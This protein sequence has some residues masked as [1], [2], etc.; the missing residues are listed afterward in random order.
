MSLSWIAV[1][2]QTQ[3]IAHRSTAPPGTLEVGIAAFGAVYVG[4]ALFMA[5]APHAFYTVIG[6]FETLNVHYI[7]D[8][9]TFNAAIG[10][11]LLVAVR[12]PSWQVPALAISTLQF[13]LH[14]I[15]HL[16]DIDRA[17]PAWV[18]YFDFFSLAVATLGLAWL[19]QVALAEEGTADTVHR[20]EGAPQ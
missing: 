9:A 5:A 7:R 16:V 17:H 13:A 10:V 18:G 4:L 11:G 8:A 2:A 19:L 14:S 15:N 6:P 20:P 1:T 3:P 12:R